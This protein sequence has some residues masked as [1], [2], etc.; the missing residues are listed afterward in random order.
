MAKEKK[1]TATEAQETVNTAEQA[2]VAETKED[3]GTMV[4]AMQEVL[5]SVKQDITE[6]RELV[7]QVLQ[8]TAAP[9]A[10]VRVDKIYRPMPKPAAKKRK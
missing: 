6:L 7:L 4:S 10:P 1:N 8:Q 3:T 9:E 2:Q 5:N